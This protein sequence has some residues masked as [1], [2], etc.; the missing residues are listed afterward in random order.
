MAEGVGFDRL[1][2]APRDVR[3]GVPQ[4]AQFIREWGDTRLGR[5]KSLAT[6]I[7]RTLKMSGGGGIRPPE[8]PA[9]TPAPFAAGSPA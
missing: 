9:T 6:T 3:C 8:A 5:G 7:T 2:L 1:R 4:G